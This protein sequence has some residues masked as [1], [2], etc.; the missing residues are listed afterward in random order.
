MDETLNA[1]ATETLGDSAGEPVDNGARE[2][3]SRGRSTIAF[4][5]DDLKAAIAVARMV[6]AEH[7]GRCEADRLA[8]SLDQKPT[9]GG[10]RLK[11]SAARIFGVIS[12][13]PKG[14]ISITPLGNRVVDGRTASA[15]KV[16]A[17]L[18]VP[19][20]KGLYEEYR[21][22]T[23]PNDTGLEAAIH[24]LGVTAKQVTTARQVFQR[25]AHQAGFFDRAQDRLVKPPTDRMDGDGE[26][27]TN[28]G[29][30]EQDSSRIP[31]K[32]LVKN[33]PL[34][35]GMLEE[36]PDLGGEFTEEDQNL[37]LQAIKINLSL[38][39][40]RSKPRGAQRPAVSLGDESRPNL[41]PRPGSDPI[42][43]QAS[44]S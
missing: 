8:A 28:G 22:K 4:P 42:H 3:K 33:H 25:S 27:P 32:R 16:D 20:Y 26:P 40:S 5:Y 39:Y 21:G 31:E 24:Q 12:T 7:G 36:L 34:I 23:L 37:W 11:V 1:D 18:N 14:G 9:S 19:L 2:K 17:F 29:V 35:V 41:V 30:D 13:S 6:H 10:F 15:A 44:E 38:I 43:Q